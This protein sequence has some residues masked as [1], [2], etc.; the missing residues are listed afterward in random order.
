[1]NGFNFLLKGVARR[2]MALGTIGI[3]GTLVIG[4]CGTMEQMFSMKTPEGQEKQ[5]TMPK[6]T[7]TGAASGEQANEL[8]KLVVESNNNTMKKFDEVNGKLDKLQETSS[9]DLETTRKA[10]AKLDAMADQQGT[11]EMTLFFKTGSAKLD[12]SQTQRLIRFLDYISVK[13]HGRKAIILSIGSASATGNP[14]FNKKLSTQRSAAPLPIIDQYLVNV[15]HEFYKVT[16]I[17]DL[18]AP[19]TASTDEH[20]RYQNV[21]IIAIYNT[22]QIPQVPEEK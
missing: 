11:G 8:A 5:V 21:R 15:P 13:S 19:R 12:Q 2:S 6:S 4:G 7:W 1:M 20:K 14:K 22:S 18:Y 16:G 3:I 10:L 17:G 9:Q